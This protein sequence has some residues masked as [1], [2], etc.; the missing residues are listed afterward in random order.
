[1]GIFGRLFGRSGKESDFIPSA[2]LMSED[3]FWDLIQ[4]SID[5]ADGDVDRQVKAM[6]QHLSLLPL[7]DVIAFQNRYRYFRGLAYTWE[8]WGAIYIINGGCGDDE[9]CYFR[10][11]L[12]AQG[13]NV[14][15]NALENPEWLVNL[16]INGQEAEAESM[17]YAAAVV[18]ENRTGK[19]LP[20]EY[21]ENHRVSGMEWKEEGDDLAR[22]FP[23]LWKKYN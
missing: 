14:Y 11:W 12:I 19:E 18:F 10:D 4:A 5:E 16:E 1:M 22:R 13:S 15:E 3:V 2:D 8:L 6:E 17:A 21:A 9:F 7:Q 20:A 23:N